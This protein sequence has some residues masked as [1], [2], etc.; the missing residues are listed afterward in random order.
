MS[1]SWLSRKARLCALLKTSTDEDETGFALDRIL[2]GQSVIGNSSK[3][4]EIDALRFKDGD[5]QSMGA[6]ERGQFG[7][8]DIVKCNLDG[9]L[10]VRKSIE[11]RFVLRNRE[12]CSPQIERDVLRLA[13]QTRSFW[14]PH[15]LG[16]FQTQTHL[17]LVMTYGAG[18]NLWEVLQSSPLGSRVSEEDMSWWTPQFISAIHWCHSQGFAHRDI[19]PHNF[20]ITPDAHVLLIDFG[21][22]APIENGRLLKKYCLVPCGT[23]DYVSPEIIT[24]HEQALVDLQMEPS[25]S[26]DDIYGYGPETDWWSLGAM[27]YE[28][29][30]GVAPFF[31]QVINDTYVKI[32]NHKSSLRFDSGID[33]SAAFQDLLRRFLTT[34]EQ[35]LGRRGVAEI[36]D[37]PAFVEVNWTRVAVESA[38]EGLHLPQFSIGE[39]SVAFAVDDEEGYSQPFA[40]SALFQSSPGGSELV[41]GHISP[42]QTSANVQQDDLFIGFSWGPPVDAFSSMFDPEESLHRDSFA[43]PRPSRLSVPGTIAPVL[44]RTHAMAPIPHSHPFLTP[45]RP[46]AGTI[47]QTLPR[48]S[49]VRRTVG[50]RPV[51]DREAMKQL[52][53]CI[54]MSARKRVLESGRKPRVLPTFASSTNKTIRFLPALTIPDFTSSSQARLRPS[55]V[56]PPE[57]TTESESEGPPSPSPTPRPSSAMSVLSRRSATPTMTMSGTFSGRSTFLTGN[58][59]SLGVPGPRARSRS[60]SIEPYPASTLTFED[61][62]FDELEDRHSS[63][64]DDILVLEHQ[65]DQISRRINPRS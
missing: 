10:Y 60:W 29:V 56:V 46:G 45:M 26:H 5:L 16:A 40:F 2:H 51:S 18:G 41:S 43:T 7:L 1:T 14:A 23:C 35:R 37:H 3:T 49:T 48:A 22:A 12:Q 50:G 52:A 55:V 30:Y 33:V 13:R 61:D 59:T 31:A 53:E 57:E 15:L 38:P 47:H 39:S 24:A 9:R 58:S 28:M 19:K 4:A 32:V 42:L 65:L 63:I 27:L 34:A 11:K 20:V 25:F 36:Q 6:L 17:N 62:T 21:S 54:G 8:I 64:M 44:S